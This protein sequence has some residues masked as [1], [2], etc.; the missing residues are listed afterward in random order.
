MFGYDYS[1]ALEA[2]SD[3]DASAHEPNGVSATAISNPS[4][5][6]SPEKKP[7]SST[8]LTSLVSPSS[9][10][11]EATAAAS[12][13]RD[14]VLNEPDH[15][16][17]AGGENDD[18]D[19]VQS[20]SESGDSIV[21]P[22][23]K[24]FKSSLVSTAAPGSMRKHPLDE[25]DSGSFD[26][27]GGMLPSTGARRKTGALS[28]S[29]AAEKPVVLAPSSS[30]FLTSSKDALQSPSSDG[31]GDDFKVDSP[32]PRMASI[33][34]RSRAAAVGGS[35]EDDED[36]DRDDDD[37]PLK[38]TFAVA[39]PVPALPPLP[40]AFPSLSSDDQPAYA[41]QNLE[42]EGAAEKREDK[43]AA[44]VAAPA[45]SKPI[46]AIDDYSDP[47]GTAAVDESSRGGEETDESNGYEDSFES[48]ASGHNSPPKAQA[49]AARNLSHVKEEEN[50]E[51]E[52]QEDYTDDFF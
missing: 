44:S 25:D 4:E 28:S 27:I 38:R 20:E 12:P 34:A 36:S 19:V 23:P 42:E 46:S 45:T 21:I 8:F 30:S 9:Q 7:G 31:Y 49:P 22:E 41:T 14:A 24:P 29:L 47:L 5:A 48:E 35:R 17:T 37:A 10:L 18:E 33:R 11:S 15:S 1:V 6:Y 43:K 2:S 32:A 39:I 50:E 26:D 13:D 52:D 40:V 51:D 3:S 16:P